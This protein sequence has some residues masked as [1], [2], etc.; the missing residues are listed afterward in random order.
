MKMLCSNLAV[1]SSYPNLTTTASEWLSKCPPTATYSREDYIYDSVKAGVIAP[2]FRSF[3]EVQVSENC[4]DGKT[5][6]IQYFVSPDYL[7]VGSGGPEDTKSDYIRVPMFPTTAQKIAHDL[8]CMLPSRKMV[9]TIYKNCSEKLPVV[10]RSRDMMTTQTFAEQSRR[11]DEFRTVPLSS[12]VAG[13]KKD[14][15]ITNRLYEDMKSTQTYRK[16]VSIYGWF[17][18]NGKPVQGPN[19]NTGS[20][21]DT[22]VDYSHG[23]RLIKSHCIV[24]GKDCDLIDVYRNPVLCQLI[25]DEGPILHPYYQV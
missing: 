18:S 12:L 10:T 19:P 22:Y 9:D 14:I 4:R 6:T 11:I 25:S 17:L 16:K 20:H 23:V 15:I 13:H 8:D 21:S 1:N 7:S 3:V 24:D 5:H 2:F